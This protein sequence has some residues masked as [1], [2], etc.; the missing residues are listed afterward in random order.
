ME[1]AKGRWDRPRYAYTLSIIWICS[2][3][4]SRWPRT[5]LPG[6][7]FTTT[8]VHLQDAITCKYPDLH[9]LN[10]NDVVARHYSTLLLCVLWSLVIS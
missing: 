4:H 3:L 5:P 8:M 7:P 10:M 6:S 9:R 2:W 1:D